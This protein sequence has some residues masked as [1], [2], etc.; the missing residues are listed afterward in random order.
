V[1]G[2]GY[3]EV[4]PRFTDNNPEGGLS[5]VET[6]FE[7]R[8]RLTDQWGVVA[9][10][11][12]GTVGLQNNPDFTHPKYGAGIGVRY[13]LGFGPLRFDIATPLNPGRGDPLLQIYLSIGQSF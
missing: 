6:S 13:N 10:L 1:R 9:F 4:G 12:G 7:V 3:Q 5:L 11:D 2:Y 8:K